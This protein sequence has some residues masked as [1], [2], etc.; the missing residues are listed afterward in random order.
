MELQQEHD[1]QTQTCAAIATAN[2]QDMQAKVDSNVWWSLDTLCYVQHTCSF[3][4]F[5]L[6]GTTPT[7][8]DLFSDPCPHRSKWISA[9]ADC[10][11]QFFRNIHLVSIQVS[12]Q[13]KFQATK[14]LVSLM[15]DIVSGTTPFVWFRQTSA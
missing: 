9:R 6:K 1:F 3:A 2:W 10:G 5:V 13:T 14:N 8:N 15:Y 12:Q 4:Q 11:S 7:A